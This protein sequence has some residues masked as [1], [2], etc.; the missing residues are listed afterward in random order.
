MGLQVIDAT[1]GEIEDVQT[2]VKS[3]VKITDTTS[4]SITSF[5][6][7]QPGMTVV[8]VGTSK[9]GVYEVTQIIVTAT[10]D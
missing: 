8:V 6:N 10:I 1:T 2:V 7:I 4:S 3:N 5:K 9:Y